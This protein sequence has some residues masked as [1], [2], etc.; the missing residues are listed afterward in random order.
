MEKDPPRSRFRAPDLIVFVLALVVL[1]LLLLP[2]FRL[3][4]EA[5]ED[6]REL[7]EQTEADATLVSLGLCI[8]EVIGAAVEPEGRSGFCAW[9]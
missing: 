9:G 7:V 8:V 5:L 2:P 4:E 3:E 6:P 1:W